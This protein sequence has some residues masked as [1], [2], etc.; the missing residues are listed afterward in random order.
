RLPHLP[1]LARKR[2]LKL[3]G[4]LDEVSLIQRPR[5]VKMPRLT[6]LNERYAPS[7]RLAELILH[8][9]SI[10][11]PKGQLAATA[12]I[13]DMNKVFEDFVS[14]AVREAMRPFGGEVR[15]QWRGWLDRDRQLVIKPD[16]TWWSGERCLAIADAKYKALELKSMPNADAYQMLA[17]CTALGLPR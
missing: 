9:S 17:Y 16:I 7:L 14:V 15:A 1:L 11:A 3:R 5:E 6:R 13:F 12:F 4:L 8:A 2:L 10:D